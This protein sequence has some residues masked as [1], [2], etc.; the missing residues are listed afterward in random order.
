MGNSSSVSPTLSPT[1]SKKNLLL[2]SSQ[3]Q[4][5]WRCLSKKSSSSQLSSCASN[6]SLKSEN[7]NSKISTIED[8]KSNILSINNTFDKNNSDHHTT[9]VINNK[10]T[11][12]I[13][14]SSRF[15]DRI[16][17]LSST[18][19]APNEASTLEFSDTTSEDSEDNDLDRTNSLEN[20]DLIESGVSLDSSKD[21][22]L[23][24][25]RESIGF[26][27]KKKKVNPSRNNLLISSSTNASSS[28]TS[29]SEPLLRNTHHSNY[30]PSPTSPHNSNKNSI[31]PLSSTDSLVDEDYDAD[32]SWLDQPR[33][34]LFLHPSSLSR[35]CQFP[36]SSSTSSPTT[37]KSSLHPT[38]IT[39]TV[40]EMSSDDISSLSDSLSSSIPSLPSTSI[41]SSV[42]SP[43]SASSNFTSSLSKQT[44]SVSQNDFRGKKDVSQQ[45]YLSKKPQ[46][47]K[48]KSNISSSDKKK[49][50]LHL[51]SGSLELGKMFSKAKSNI[52]FVN[53]LTQ[54]LDSFSLKTKIKEALKEFRGTSLTKHL[55]SNDE[56][57]FAEYFPVDESALPQT[58]NTSP[59]SKK[60]KERSV[61]VNIDRII[62]VVQP[63]FKTPDMT[64]A[65]SETNLNTSQSTTPQNKTHPRV[66]RSNALTNKG[67]YMDFCGITS[68]VTEIMNDCEDWTSIKEIKSPFQI[69][70]SEPTN[71]AETFHLPPPQD[72]LE[73][74]FLTI[75]DLNDEDDRS[76]QKQLTCNDKSINK[77]VF[78]I[79]TDI[80][81]SFVV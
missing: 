65:Q 58:N 41:Q 43:S 49:D 66:T 1:P 64:K 3:R 6:K 16:S 40:V 81:N 15:A 73:N 17:R 44:S 26:L 22:K 56:L 35:S 9:L 53:N 47:F 29:P 4:Q 10:L 63:A 7:A 70:I 14:S 74:R 42:T 55:I 45:Q 27:K 57:S 18:N 31:R 77:N 39:T 61:A 59:T 37:T 34:A 36:N 75:P 2:N 28:S 24:S 69:E 79:V 60:T 68:N 12:S 72:D 50:D 80:H 71:K 23:S 48:S 21:S 62:D 33:S 76:E 78:D 19:K 51:L 11:A 54:S 5:S 67:Y 13:S 20:H 52:S 30:T 8:T 25:L 38:N 32:Q 46:V